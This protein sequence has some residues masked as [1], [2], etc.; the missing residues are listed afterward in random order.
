MYIPYG[1][2]N[3]TSEDIERVKTFLRDQRQ[4]RVRRYLNLKGSRL[5]G[6]I[7]GIAVNSATSA[8]HSM[9]SIRRKSR[10]QCMD[11]LD[12]L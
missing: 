9:Q 10:R 12:K 6:G 7:Y 2:Q 8:L 3:I 1:K 4:H 11:K 5:K